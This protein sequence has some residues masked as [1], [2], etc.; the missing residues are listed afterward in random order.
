M[1]AASVPNGVC[2]EVMQPERDPLCHALIE[3]R[4]PIRDG[5]MRLPEAPGWGLALDRKVEQR[6]RAG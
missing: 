4:P 5:R 6:L 3:N 2:V 1:L